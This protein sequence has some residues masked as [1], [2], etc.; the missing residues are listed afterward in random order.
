M[1]ERDLLNKLQTI[2]FDDIFKNPKNIQ[3]NPNILSLLRHLKDF[4]KHV[5]VFGNSQTMQKDQVFSM[6]NFIR[7]PDLFFIL[8]PT[9]VQNPLVAILNG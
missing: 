2:N 6:I 9:F 4:R 3:G 1:N 5:M 7:M 8:N